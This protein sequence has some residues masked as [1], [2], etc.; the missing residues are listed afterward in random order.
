MKEYKIAQIGSFD[1]ENYGDLLFPDVLEKCLSKRIKIMDIYLFSPNGGNKPFSNKKVYP[2]KDLEKIIKEKMFD[3]III[4]GGDIIRLD[5]VVTSKYDFSYETAYSFWQIPI[6]LANK[7]NIKVVFNAPGVPYAFNSSQLVFN[8]LLLDMVNYISV[9]DVKSKEHLG[10]KYQNKCF[11]VPDTINIISEIYQKEELINNKKKLIKDKTIPKLNDYIIFQTKIISENHNL[12]TDKIKELLKYITDIDGKDVLLM[13]IGYVHND[14]DFCSKFADN[15]N[16]KIH[17]LKNK[18]SPYD[19]LSVIASSSG[20]IGTSLHGLITSNAY[21]VKIM[22]INTENLVKVT[23]FLNLIKKENLEVNDMNN[24]LDVYKLEFN[25]QDFHLND[26][27]KQKVYHHFNKIADIIISDNVRNIDVST[28]YK[29]LNYTY[30]LIDKYE[31]SKKLTEQAEQVKNENIFLKTELEKIFNSKS[32]RVILALRKIISLVSRK[33][34]IN[35]EYCITKKSHKLKKITKK[36]AIQIH[37]FYIDLLDELLKNL[38]MFPFP[39]DLYISTDTKEK[40]KNIIAFLKKNNFSNIFIVEIYENRGRDI[41]P[42]LQQMKPVINNYDYILHLHTKKSKYADYGDD[43]RRYLYYT[44][45]GNEDNI[46]SIFYLFEKKIKLGLIFPVTY[47]KIE[48]MMQIGGSKIEVDT[49]CKRMNIEKE[50]NNVFPAGSMFWAKVDAILPLFNNFSKEDF[51]IENNQRDG[52]FAHAVERI[53]VL[54][55]E[56][57]G[58]YYLQTKNNTEEEQV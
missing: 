9:R 26:I 36:I 5:K 15:T 54:L 25:N 44:L 46:R 56:S 38:I 13:P 6:M 40:K 14:I 49:L 1:V 34:Q 33:S 29:F 23:G 37:I 48:S 30:D 11:V 8:E 21:D 22:A 17:I 7:Y 28:N 16:K 51:A 43:W 27:I 2:I 32:F 53:F 20:F 47:N 52:T 12:Y 31:N 58:Y 18:L 57:R 19:M 24:C 39:F 35:H 50:F 42:F 45:L 41:Y 3:V 55:V 4:G 10:K